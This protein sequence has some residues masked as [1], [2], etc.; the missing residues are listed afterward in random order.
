MFVM[1]VQ[2]L[3]GNCTLKYFIHIVEM[4]NLQYFFLNFVTIKLEHNY[5]KM[6][7]LLFFY[8]AVINLEKNFECLLLQNDLC[9]FIVP[10]L[11]FGDFWSLG[12]PCF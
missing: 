6:Q 8:F 10:L 3:L 9:D 2:I 1:K 4:M 11:K 5:W 12:R 7:N